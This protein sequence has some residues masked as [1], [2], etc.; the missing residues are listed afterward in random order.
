MIKIIN[1]DLNPQKKIIYCLCN[2]YGIGK[3]ISLKLCHK[4]NINPILKWDEIESIKKELLINFI[5]KDIKTGNQIKLIKSY[6]INQYIINGSIRGFR[7]KKHLPVRGQR[8]HS[9]AKTNKRLAHLI[10]QTK[11]KKK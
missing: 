1:Y 6:N 8:T 2:I 9:N 7:H 11:K 10:K 3:K 5:E 4:F